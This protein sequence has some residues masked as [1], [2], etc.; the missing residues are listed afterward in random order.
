M[1]YA[2][3]IPD[4][5]PD[6]PVGELGNRTP[7]EAGRLPNINWVA[8]HGRTGTATHVPTNMPPGSDIAIMSLIGYNPRKNYNGRA[9][10]EAAGQKI[11][12]GPKEWVFRANLVSI[13][14]GKM[15]DYSAGH[16]SSQEA[17]VLIKLLAEKSAGK[18]VK[19]YPG[20]SYRH[21][22]VFADGKF[23]KLRSTPPH[24]IIGQSVQKYRLK[25]KDAEPLRELMD[26]AAELFENHEINEV[27]RQL[28][29]SPATNI[30]LWG[31]GQRTEL[32]QFSNRFG[33]KGALIAGTDL[34]KGLA[35][36]VGWEVIDVAGAT[37]YLDTDYKAKGRAAV[38]ALRQYDLVTV[39]VEAPDEAGHT[40]DAK[41]KLAALEAIDKHIVGPVL[42]ELRK[43]KQW[44]ILICPDH[45]TPV[46]LRTHVAKPVPFAMAGKGITGVLADNFTEAN[47]EAADLHIEQGWELMEYF[48][49][50]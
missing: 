25:G 45:P 32:E 3:I 31:Q 21:L 40:G 33:L 30:W 37:G 34:I 4:G 2:V 5:A 42:E 35:R 9:P 47:A 14:D 13:I 39:H 43:N 11:K 6:E 8:G 18:G 27:R 46:R 12:L 26:L 17:K 20:V 41:A 16:I 15:V 10:I 23:N 38:K 24:D 36:L 7:L 1:R 19:F 49:K 29:E 44:R 28:N 50:A 22:A 48:L